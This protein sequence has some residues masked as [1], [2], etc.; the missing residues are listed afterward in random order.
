MNALSRTKC[1]RLMVAFGLCLMLAGPLMLLW[2]SRP[3]IAPKGDNDAL[4]QA[5]DENDAR[6]AGRLRAKLPPVTLR[7]VDYAVFGDA[8]KVARRDETGKKGLL[9]TTFADIDPANV[10]AAL[11]DLPGNLKFSEAEITRMGPKGQIAA[12]VNYIML[13]PEAIASK[14]LDAVLARL[15]E[16]VKT[17]ISYEANSTILAYV[18]PRHF[19]A[20]RQNEDIRFIFAMHPADKIDLQ[21]GRRPLIER[22]RAL[23]PNFLLEVALV[24]GSSASAVR[25]KMEKIPGVVDVANYGA[26]G[27]GLLVRVDHKSLDKLAR[28]P[29]V[30]QMQEY[31]EFMTNNAKNGPTMQVGSA[32]E[33]LDIRP[34]DDL[35]VDGGGI[36]SNGDGQRNNAINNPDPVPPQIVGVLDNGISAD[37]PSWSQT[38]TQVSDG[39]AHIFPS[40]N[41]RKIHSIIA[42]RDNGNDCDATLD[43]GGSHGN[44]VAS[45]I[46]A[47]PSQLGVYANDANKISV[48]SQIHNANLDGVA[49]G[50]RI[51]VTDLA[52]RTRCAAAFNA[53]VEKG[54]NV[55]PGRLRDRLNELICPK[56]GGTGACSGIV[57]GA[58]EVHLAITPFGA[59][60]NFQ[61]SQFL[62]SNGTYPQQARDIDV[63]LY[64]N[65]DFMVVAPVGNNGA[66]IGNNRP[67]LWLRII[68]DLFNGTASDDC[69]VP[70]LNP[71][72]HPIQ[73][74]PPSTAKNL[75]SVGTSRSDCMTVFGN[76]DCQANHATFSSRGPASPE[77]L[78]MAPIL[79]A[80]GSDLIG[81]NFETAS[82]AV[83]RSRDDDNL[84][85]IDAQID[86]G[87]F[88]TSYSA[89]NVMGEAAIIRDYFAQGLYPTGDRVAGNRVPNV[90]GAL[91]KAALI[92]SA[93]FGTNVRNQGQDAGEAAIRRTRA[94]DLGQVVGV[95]VGVMGNSEQGYGLP[96][97]S[98]V[99]AIPNWS[100]SFV[101]GIPNGTR[102]PAGTGL[103]TLEYPA[104]AVLV[105]DDIATGE[106][107][108]DNTHT[109]QT[110]TFT[111]SSPQILFSACVGGPTPAAPC[112]KTAECG[113]GGTCTGGLAATHAQLRVGLAWTDP[114]SAQDLGG[115]LVND[116]DLVV[117]SPGPDNCLSAADTKPNGSA[118]PA[119]AADDNQFF[120]GNVYP[121]TKNQFSDQWSKFRSVG[122][123]ETH[124]CRNPQEAVHLTWDFAN[125]GEAS[126][127]SQIYVGKWRVTVKRSTT[128][129]Q[130]PPNTGG[131]TPGFI[132]VTGP[133]EDTGN[134]LCTGAGNPFACCTGAGAGSCTGNR[135]LDNQN[136]L[137]T[138]GPNSQPPA[139]PAPFSCCLDLYS[140]TCPNEDTNANGL[141][142][143]GGQ[144]YAL[145]VSGP[146]YHDPAEAPPAKGPTG[147]PSSSISVN[148]I[149]YTCSDNLL[150]EIFDG[151]A[152]SGVSRST[153]STTFTVKRPDGTILDTENGIGF[154]AGSAPGVTES[155]GVPIRLSNGPAVPNNGI[156][157]ADNG[158]LVFATYAPA[159]QAAVAG[160]ARVDCTPS[161]LPNQFGIIDNNAVGPTLQ[162]A[163]GCDNDE[164]LDAGETVTYG[165]ALLNRGRGLNNTGDDYGDVT[166]T[167]TPSGP[168]AGA[169]RVLDSPKNL[170]RLPASAVNGIFFHVFVDPTL[171]NALP[172][173]SRKVTMTLTLDSLNRGQRMERLS[174]AFT[175]AINADRQTLHYSTDFPT[176]GREIRDL[177]RNLVI[178][179]PDQL[180]PFLRY[181]VPDEDVTF[182][183]LFVNGTTINGTPTITN[184]LG[185]DLNN[186]GSLD[187]NELDIIPNG[188]LD[189]GIL[190]S[191]GGPSSGD[192]IPWH[193]DTGDGGW[194]PIRHPAS[195]PGNLK[196]G[197]PIWE[198]ETN[199]RCGYQSSGTGTGHY[200]IWHTGDGDPTT[201]GPLSTTCE[202]HAVPQD[203]ATE[204]NV[205]VILDI[206]HSPIIAKVHQ[207][208]DSLNFNYGVEFQRIAFNL[209]DQEQ[210]ASY[211]GVGLNIDNNLDEDG[212]NCFF[213]QEMDAYYTRRFGG[214]PRTVLDLAG[215]GKQY[216]GYSYG[217][218][219][220]VPPGYVDQRTFGPFN[221][222]NGG[223][224]VDGGGET[225]F[226][227]FT[228]NSNLDSK[229]PIPTAGKF[230]LKFPQVGDAV[231]GVCTGGPTPG[232]PCQASS[233]CGTGGT[234]TLETISLTP[235]GPVRN[236]DFSL[237]GY[238]GSLVTDNRTGLSAPERSLFFTPG[239]AGNRWAIGFG[240]YGIESTAHLTDYGWGLDDIVFEWDEFHPAPETTPA[241]SKFNTPG[242]PAGGQ[243]ATL[244]ADRTNLYECEEAMEITVMDSKLPANTP[245]VTVKV[246]TD[247]DSNP[248]SIPGRFSVLRPNAK[249]YTLNAAPLGSGFFKGTVAFSGS[250]NT[251]S[252]V[253][254]NPSTDSTFIVY[255]VDAGCDGDGDGQLGETAFDNLD[256]DGVLSPVDGG[257]DNCPLIYNPNQL[258]TDGDGVG[259][260]CDNCVNVANPTQADNNNDGVGD[261]CDYDDVDGDGKNNTIDNCPDVYNPGQELGSAPPK[262]AACS[263]TTQDLDGDG[264][265]DVNDNCVLTAN[266]NQKNSDG[267]GLGDACDGDCAGNT[268]IHICANAPGTACTTDSQCPALPAVPGPHCQ[269]MLSHAQAAICS[270]VDDDADLDGVRDDLDDCA[271]I[272][273]PTIIPGSV[274]PRQL[275]SDRDGLGDACDPSGSED[276]DFNGIPDD[277]V[278]F[279][280]VVSCRVFPLA[281]LVVTDADYVDLDGDHDPFPDTG[282]TGLVQVS[283]KNTG[284]SLT[285]AAFT[286]TSP[287]PNVGC[288]ISPTV[289]AASL[290]A[291]A[292]I[293]LGSLNPAAPQLFKFRASDTL[294][295][296]NPAAPT[297]ITLCLGVTANESLGTASPAC[298]QLLADISAPGGAQPYV[299]GP[300]GI[301]GTSDDGRIFESFD[302]DRDGDGKFTVND[303]FRAVDGGTGVVH[304]FY[305]HG[306]TSN[307]THLAD[308]M[309]GIPCGGFFTTDQNNP[310]CILDDDFPM[311]WHLHC[312]HAN[313]ALC[314]NNESGTFTGG[315]KGTCKGCS[316]NTPADAGGDKAFTP[317]NSLHMGAHFDLS[318]AALGDTTHFRS[319]QAFVSA[320]INLGLGRRV[321]HPEDLTMSFYHIADL[322]DNEGFG[323]G[324]ANQCADCAD[325]QVQVDRDQNAA[326]DDWGPWDKLVP[327]ANA[328]DHKV[329][330]WS[331][332]GRSDCIQTPNDAGTQ[333]PAPR[334]FHETI[335]YPQG[336]WSHCGS[337]TS[338]DPVGGVVDCVGAVGVPGGAGLGVWVQTAFNLKPYQGA[339]IRIRWVGETWDFLGDGTAS[340]YFETGPGWSNSAND[341]G[342]WLDNILIGGALTVQTLP[343]VDSRPIP[344]GSSCPTNP[345]TF[346][347]ETTAASDKGTVPAIKATDLNGVVFD[348]VNYVP[349]AG[350]SIRISA[351]ASTL[352]GGCTNGVPQFQFTKNGVVVQDWSS[353]PFFQDSPDLVATYSVLVRCSSD[354]SCTSVNGATVTVPVY[355]GTDGVVFGSVHSAFDPSTGVQYTPPGGAGTTTL[356]LY[357]PTGFQVDVYRGTIT[358]LG[359]ASG[360]SIDSVP[361]NWDYT[362]G[363]GCFKKN[364]NVVAG[365]VT[366][367][368]AQ[369]DD[370]NPTLGTATYYLANS[371]PNAQI[372]TNLGCVTPGRCRL[373]PNAS[374]SDNTQCAGA[375]NAC[376]SLLQPGRC[377]LTPTILCSST[378]QCPSAAN[379]V[380]LVGNVCNNIVQEPLQNNQLQVDYGCPTPNNSPNRL[381]SVAVAAQA[382]VCMP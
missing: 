259:D 328:Y 195:T 51:I 271:D 363:T 161:F 339:R 65:R 381:P 311:D 356:N 21:T 100:K 357:T 86:E 325:V 304:G 204:N 35:G 59:P 15:R 157:E 71:N 137:C 250:A 202:N 133:N 230:Q 13:R 116:L 288:I 55:D 296:T 378:S 355:S 360:G 162:V 221:D 144:T 18:E 113:V 309:V 316:Y 225:G 82:I 182:S 58:D 111:V 112:T 229:S 313:P 7:P 334:G 177:N 322:M 125:N 134:T 286:L 354:T 79:F 10:D 156:L 210:D 227:A 257:T 188:Q 145:V 184:L 99:L 367:A 19:G 306:A 149:R 123:P 124:D 345:A 185:E 366:V 293:V 332:V 20:L 36:D 16:Q 121:G 42:T 126:A 176:G 56:S 186:N 350:H 352:P 83:F 120:D 114:P 347:D 164:N 282:E 343:V 254:T 294:T 154:T 266:A 371:A 23:D 291:G 163:G 104:R 76:N 60:D 32:T 115:P 118:C 200:G 85:P 93:K 105:W 80:P 25:A 231:P 285:D 194:K 265:F 106:P 379:G 270:L 214:W 295:T 135:R 159:G 240:F 48:A 370:A 22:A 317:P 189:R 95:N 75:I 273:N 290:P 49:R 302:N 141:L 299:F 249:S 197:N 8:Y 338:V 361:P 38:A 213:C 122:Q 364:Q 243:C 63:F 319:L 242:N 151:T 77:S 73:V 53:L 277:I 142:D 287:D 274:P 89:A 1:I 132:T 33:G 178:D 206:L 158:T 327:S 198:Y 269:T 310:G 212:T 40:P 314:P 92:A 34:F 84:A 68:P 226:S 380:P 298:F 276:D 205:E 167:L 237:V 263:S 268:V 258:D 241:C 61:T 109:S 39:L 74:A 9:R 224:P 330:A 117:E 337:P 29:E 324:N 203:A 232:G 88:G 175:N 326:S 172:A 5:L 94:T 281:H 341:D 280:G 303:T 353:K 377:S 101:L 320:P 362:A 283:V 244:T 207:E 275:D 233:D 344:A 136:L 87:N 236:M 368:L 70:C 235:Y 220:A 146:V 223:T 315:V 174:F 375:G 351:A 97:L 245:S 24:P 6:L 253:F 191:A 50:A 369:V 168:G 139:T 192:K 262:G 252:N 131:S 217:I 14:G 148:K 216:F 52:D 348:G 166:G 199:G 376:L 312:P 308:L 193:F 342:W 323:P 272:P 17:I 54:G 81:N 127:D 46:A 62:P 382:N 110:H 219:P 190:F 340:S 256:G 119:N 155:S 336:A 11:R 44:T 318:N 187:A 43:G 90:S 321:D 297:R 64:N 130:C 264:K 267:D 150:A 4:D 96:I 147:F 372:N 143:L 374:C 278:S 30:L 358:S 179:K 289:S 140:G 108:I 300:D 107:A 128:S 208:P 28:I 181:I 169:I 261:V 222:P 359:S 284:F 196:T 247:S 152:G 2:A 246:V 211:N 171:A 183:S 37:T 31:L 329:E 67:E 47:Y 333:N 173:A 129:S 365:N 248:F 239:D 373:A 69:P 238:E 301:N 12:G 3:T 201:P 209:M 57:G 279:T 72:P 292:E 180:D 170:G 215:Y 305:A 102:T 255:Y 260:L 165:I 331:T 27:S 98:H 91:V 103:E 41:H 78:R 218:D 26:D 45:V 307:D 346:C 153:A 234:C 335:C 160:S 349:R 138:A 228:Q 251:P 66:N